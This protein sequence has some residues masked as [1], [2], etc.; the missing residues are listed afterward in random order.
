MNFSLKRSWSFI[1]LIF[2]L[3]LY[4]YNPVFKFIG[5]GSIKLF[6]IPCILYLIFK[7]NTLKYLGIFKLEFFFMI[8]LIFYVLL[9][10][11]MNNGNAYNVGYS[12]FLFIIECI[13]IPIG[14][15]VFFKDLILKIGINK[16]FIVT[17]F[18][19][20]LISISLLVIPD[21]NLFVRQNIIV[22]D[23]DSVD[24]G[25]LQYI[26]GFTI[27]GESTF[28]YG[29][30]QGLIFGI[31]LFES[32]KSAKYL[33]PLFPLI[34]SIM[35]NARVGFFMVLISIFLMVNK[36]NLKF[37]SFFIF[38]FLLIVFSISMASDDLLK[39]LEWSLSFF[40]ESMGFL[41]GDISSNSTYSVL[42][43]YIIFPD[44][45]LGLLFGLGQIKIGFGSDIGYVNHIFTGGF[46]YLAFMLLILLLVY[47]RFINF[48]FSKILTALFIFS[49]LV[50]N[51]KGP[52]L[53]ASQTFFRLIMF[54]YV[55]FAVNKYNNLLNSKSYS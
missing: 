1:I 11:L 24:M 51:L 8:L 5:I 55:F 43:D 40:D 15:S 22:D 6:W 54:Y 12:H 41:K 29:I 4:I 46:F 28:G 39:S 20:S 25:V 9:V 26:R 34:I 42:S 32:K 53:F 36:I 10:T 31:C 48:G 37:I 18:I 52:G 35:L 13:I 30:I 7:K 23:L 3:Y 27:S 47:I 21:L 16:S 17:G 2:I 49:I 19:A 44:T 33:I 14:L 50:L 45:Y 38:I